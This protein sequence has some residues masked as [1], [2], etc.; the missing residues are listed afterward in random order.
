MPD[1]FQ[2]SADAVSAPATRCVAVTPNDATP[3]TDIPKALFVGTGGA[4]TLRGVAD[5]ADTV[6]KNV[7]AGA[8]LPFRARYVRA[9]GT[10]AGD[11]L[12]LY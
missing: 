3:L 2:N 4:L 7:P 5:T 1:A 9:A 8:L 6:W 11:I 10:S 12:A